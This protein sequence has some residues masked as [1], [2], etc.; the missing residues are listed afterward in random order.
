MFI[1]DYLA[2]RELYTP[3]RL[4]LVDAGKSPAL[5]LTYAQMNTR[6]NSLASWLH[7]QGVGSG[8]RVVILARDG[9]EHLD[10][11]FDCT[12]ENWPIFWPILNRKRSFIRPNLRRPS[13]SCRGQ[14]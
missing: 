12:G 3:N 5:R 13:S 4:A 8:D 10:L 2:R 6:A 11:F 7:E 1:G 9:V 14:A